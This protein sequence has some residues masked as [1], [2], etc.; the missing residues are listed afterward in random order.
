MTLLTRWETDWTEAWF[1]TFHDLKWLNRPDFSFNSLYF[2]SRFLS[3]WWA[4]LKHYFEILLRKL[5]FK[6]HDISRVIEKELKWEVQA[7][8]TQ[9]TSRYLLYTY[10]F[11]NQI[12]SRLTQLQCYFFVLFWKNCF[13]KINLQMQNVNKLH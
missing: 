3:R 7:F 11:F 8:E 4:W 1:L 5:S 10:C 9:S 6:M 12:F 13:M 2:T